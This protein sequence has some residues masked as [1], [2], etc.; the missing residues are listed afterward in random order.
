MSCCKLKTHVWWFYCIECRVTIAREEVT[1]NLISS[2]M[3]LSLRVTVEGL[4]IKCGLLFGSL[5]AS[6]SQ[7]IYMYSRNCATGSLFQG[8]GPGCHGNAK[9]R[10]DR[11]N[12]SPEKCRCFSTLET[13][14][15]HVVS[16]K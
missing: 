6:A 2:L 12:K 16:A 14:H 7:Y 8:Q 9:H 5:N 1:T 13:V 10:P 3:A 15:I 11:Q 4:K